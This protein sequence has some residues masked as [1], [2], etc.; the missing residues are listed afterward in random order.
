MN[1][2]MI[3][4]ITLIITIGMLT[5]GTICKVNAKRYDG[6]TVRDAVVVDGEYKEI[7]AY[8]VGGDQEKKESANNNGTFFFILGGVTGIIC[9]L[10]FVADQKTKKRGGK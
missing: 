2:K 7:D 8:E 3:M 5:M 1:K 9:I 4:V 10:T 6:V